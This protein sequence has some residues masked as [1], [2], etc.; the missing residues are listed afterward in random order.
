[1]L[2]EFIKFSIFRIYDVKILDFCIHYEIVSDIYW[3]LSR[4]RLK[5]NLQ[6]ILTGFF[7]KTKLFS[8]M[9]V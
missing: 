3:I 8:A 1:M 9:T 2:S 5:L 4:F 7:N 6:C